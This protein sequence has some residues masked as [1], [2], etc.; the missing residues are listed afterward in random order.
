MP[1]SLFPEKGVN[2]VETSGQWEQRC[3]IS[4]KEYTQID[5]GLDLRLG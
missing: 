5:I 2:E 4:S 1:V 3:R